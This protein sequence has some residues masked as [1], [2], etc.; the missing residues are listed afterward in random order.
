[1]PFNI[2]LD[3]PNKQVYTTGDAVKGRVILSSAKDEAVGQISVTFLGRTKT[4]I[5]K[6]NGNSSHIYRGRGT[7]FWYSK[8]LYQGHYT[9]RADTYEWPFEFRFPSESL[10]RPVDSSFDRSPPFLANGDTHPL[11]SSFGHHG[12]GFSTNFECYVEYKLEASLTRPPDA[13]LFSS[14]METQRGIS[15]LPPRNIQHP[16]LRI[17]AF[18]QSCTAQT[19]RLLPE[20]ADAKFTMKEKMKSTFSKSDL[21]TAIFVVHFTYPTVLYAGSPC[22]FRIS[23]QHISNTLDEKA[24]MKVR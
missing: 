8:V 14:G 1:M 22:P 6:R 16:N 13:G 5:R 4:K 9:L 18:S 2:L 20:K 7:L 19:L 17:Q 15:F 23:V 12:A 21:P 11:P 10:A 3:D 24:P